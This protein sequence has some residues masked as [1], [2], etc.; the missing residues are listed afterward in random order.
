MYRV[1]GSDQKE[2]GPISLEQVRQWIQENRLN[3]YSLAATEADPVWKP[4]SQFPELADVLSSQPSSIASVGSTPPPPS[5]PQP[6]PSSSQQPP[7]AAYSIPSANIGAAVPT[8]PAEKQVLGPSIG[9]MVLGG[10][11]CIYYLFSGVSAFFMDWSTYKFPGEIP[12]GGEAQ[13]EAILEWFQK[14]G[15]T[16]GAGMYFVLALL[17][18]LVAFGGLQ[19]NRLR[20]PT[21]CWIA[22]ILVIPSSTCCCCIGIPIGIWAMVVLSRSEV[23]SRMT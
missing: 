10:L 21:L 2:Y 9:L 8:T 6:A 18:G 19:M 7:S 23:R 22:S 17:N 16:I 15:G 20:M 13:M 12:P 1:K 5:A 11:F 4:L 14:Y 3:R